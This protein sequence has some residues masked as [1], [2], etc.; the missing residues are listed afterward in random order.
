MKKLLALTVLTGLAFSG[1]GSSDSASNSDE[2]PTFTAYDI[3]ECSDY[4]DYIYSDADE[5]ERQKGMVPGVTCGGVVELSPG[6]A[7]D[8]VIVLQGGEYDGKRLGL[9]VYGEENFETL[10]ALDGKQV[11]LVGD[12]Y[13]QIV[14][15]SGAGIWVNAEDI[16]EQ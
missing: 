3:K 4:F 8:S 7:F 5:V 16:T 2:W 14:D 12:L 10:S 15:A 11:D 13:T 1:C 9:H 6:S